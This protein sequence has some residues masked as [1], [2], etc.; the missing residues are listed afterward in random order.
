MKELARTSSWSPY[1]V[2][3]GIGVLSWIS[4]A[5]AKRPIGITTTFESTAAGLGQRLAPR[6]SGVN[7]YLARSEDVPR[8][9]WEWML[10]AGTLLGSLL[11]A[12]ASGATAAHPPVPAL[13]QRRFGASRRRRALGAFLGGAL[14]MFGARM[15]KGCTSGHA[16]SGTMQLAGSSWLFS[17]VMAATAAVVARALFGKVAGHAR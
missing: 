1:A 15:A 16:I 10:T 11:G 13:W 14:M 2:G 8:L 7:A 12:R 9:D 3:A 6:A 5:T 4:F 17:P